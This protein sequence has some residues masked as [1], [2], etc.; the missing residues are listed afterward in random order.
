MFGTRGGIQ[1]RGSLPT[2]GGSDRSVDLRRRSFEFSSDP[3]E[4]LRLGGE[5]GSNWKALLPSHLPS[6]RR[7]PRRRRRTAS[8]RHRSWHYTCRRPARIDRDLCEHPPCRTACLCHLFGTATRY[9]CGSEDRLAHSLG[10]S[11][12][13]PLLVEPSLNDQAAQASR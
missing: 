1:R 13:H 5:S 7:L 10:T 3:T 4:S 12:L 9:A 8:L 2:K 6:R 11:S